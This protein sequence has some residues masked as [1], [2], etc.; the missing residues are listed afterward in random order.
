MTDP[1][2]G[3]VTELLEI[4]RG[5]DVS[6]LERLFPIVYAELRGMAGREM[7]RQ[8]PAHT[9]APTDLVNEACLKLLGSGAPFQS[10]AHFFCVAAKAMRSVLVDH[11]RAK[12]SAKRGGEFE[13]TPLHEAAAVFEERAID[14]VALDEALEK[15][16]ALDPEKAKLVELR[17]FAGLP[18]PEVA[19]ILGLSLATTERHWSFARAWLRSALGPSGS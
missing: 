11:A 16:G 17:F 10:R 6:A 19:E 9:L 5:G 1:A 8:S 18:M 15:F 12:G 2:R 7:R 3:Q 4:A 13:R 14:L